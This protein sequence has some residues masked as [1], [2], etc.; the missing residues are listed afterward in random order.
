MI[1]KPLHSVTRQAVTKKVIGKDCR[2]T[3]NRFRCNKSIIVDRYNAKI[4]SGYVGKTCFVA[5]I[6]MNKNEQIK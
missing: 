3:K 1:G 6:V 2:Q 4:G 5:R